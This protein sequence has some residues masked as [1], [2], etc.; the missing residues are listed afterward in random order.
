MVQTRNLDATRLSNPKGQIA[1]G[2]KEAG[3]LL[4]SRRELYRGRN[5]GMDSCVLWYSGVGW[6]FAEDETSFLSCR[7]VGQV[8][9]MG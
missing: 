9:P 6:S 2:K 3:C 1:Q 5:V 7:V 4:I 8:Y